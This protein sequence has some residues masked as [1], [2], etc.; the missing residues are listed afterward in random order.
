MKIS[1]KK[2]K[3]IIKKNW[4]WIVFLVALIGF[5]AIAEDVF[6]QEIMRL[7]TMAYKIIVE[8]L[9]ND[10]LTNIMQIITNLGGV[11]TLV[12]LA[13]LSL[14]VIKKKKIGVAICGNLV[15]ISMLNVVLK[16]I[17]QRPRP[18]GYR[19]I[20]ESG[21][22][23]TSGHSMISTA[24]YGFIIYLIYKNIKNKYLKY[25]LCTTLGILIPLI[26]ISRVY[27]GVHYASDIIAGFLLSI[28][29]L[30]CYITIYNSIKIGES[31]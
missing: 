4:V 2:A 29:Y 13:I 21:Y 24:F 18:D 20:S 9:R 12:A 28:S 5:I 22:S 26:A 31:K 11:I 17:V 1:L 16:N 27:L 10:T 6:E 8:N 7:D 3:D 30:V 25:I 14:I 23:F 15:I 19:L